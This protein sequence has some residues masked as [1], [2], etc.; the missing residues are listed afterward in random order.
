M[1]VSV[2]AVKH[3]AQVGKATLSLDAPAHD[4]GDTS[5]IDSIPGA[6]ASPLAATEEAETATLVH[7]LL[8]TLTPREQTIVRLRF[9]IGHDSQHTLDEVGK[10]FGVTRERI[11]QIV[12]RA[13]DKLRIQAED[14][15][16]S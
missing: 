14:G 4:D 7:S 10:Q 11:R 15:L 5:L 9:G 13:L 8:T 12:A 16:P 1:G 3:A 6:G 2:A